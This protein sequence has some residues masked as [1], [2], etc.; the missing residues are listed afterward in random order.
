LERLCFS[1]FSLRQYVTR[2]SRAGTTR[3]KASL[4]QPPWT[5]CRDRFGDAPCQ[6]AFATFLHRLQKAVAPH[7]PCGECGE[8]ALSGMI[9][10]QALTLFVCLR[11]RGL[12]GGTEHLLAI[13]GTEALVGQRLCRLR[14]V[15]RG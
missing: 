14:A 5:L 12:R 6:D 8:K 7:E 11:V 10:Q 13:L 4:R 3:R 9:A 1:C 2:A 15:L